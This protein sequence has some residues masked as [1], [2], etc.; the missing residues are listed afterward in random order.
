MAVARRRR[1]VRACMVLVG[2]SVGGRW[3]REVLVVVFGSCR[4]AEC[5]VM[6]V[7]GVS[8]SVYIVREVLLVGG[9]SGAVELWDCYFSCCGPRCEANITIWVG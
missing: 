6:R 9:S 7:E 8:V 3:R 5:D 4:V 1:V 2:E